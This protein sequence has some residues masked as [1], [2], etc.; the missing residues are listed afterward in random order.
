MPFIEVAIT[1]AATFQPV[2]IPAD[3]TE[4]LADSGPADTGRADVNLKFV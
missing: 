4:N 2:A 3:D 1:T